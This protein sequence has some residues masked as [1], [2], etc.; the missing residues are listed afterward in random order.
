MFGHFDSTGNRIGKGNIV[1]VSVSWLFW[2]QKSLRQQSIA[3]NLYLQPLRISFIEENTALMVECFEADFCSSFSH[4][5]SMW[6]T[7]VYETSC[8][9][10]IALFTNLCICE[11]F[12]VL[13]PAL[14][15]CL[16]PSRRKALFRNYFSS[17]QPRTCS[18]W[19]RYSAPLIL[20]VYGSWLAGRSR[21]R[22]VVMTLWLS[23]CR[24]IGSD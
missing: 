12:A 6:H 3:S 22:H 8:R 20:V 13:C 5:L 2:M 14:R 15:W 1:T 18:F 24:R 19:R 9:W 21:W 4:Q 16:Q 10:K 17:V 7:V 11:F 23:G